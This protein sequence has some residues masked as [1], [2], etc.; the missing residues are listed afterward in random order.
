MALADRLSIQAQQK[1]RAQNLA[2]AFF[3][4]IAVL[5]VSWLLT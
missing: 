4:V 2:F 1:K 5:L 3:F